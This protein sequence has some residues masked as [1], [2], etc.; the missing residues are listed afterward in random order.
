MEVPL[1]AM[2]GPSQVG[3]AETLGAQKAQ[4]CLSAPTVFIPNHTTSSWS[5][6]LA[7]LPPHAGSTVAAPLE[8]DQSEG[9]MPASSLLEAA[10]SLLGT[11]SIG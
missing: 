7:F 6:V 8:P 3:Q 9:R 2:D 1:A 11:G 4:G 5:T 10:L